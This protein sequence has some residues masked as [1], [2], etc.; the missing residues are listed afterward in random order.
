MFKKLRSLAS[1][2]LV[3][4]L[5]A[6]LLSPII[7]PIAYAQSPHIDIIGLDRYLKAM[8]VNAVNNT[9][10]TDVAFVVRYIGGL[11]GTAQI[12]TGDL[13][14]KVGASGSEIADTTV[15]GCGG[16]AGTLAV[17]SCTTIQTLINRCNAS[18]NWRC[19]PIDSILADSVTGAKLLTLAATT[20]NKPEGLNI[21]WDNTV[22][23]ASTRLL[24]PY[25]APVIPVTGLPYNFRTAAPYLNG[26]GNVN[27]V[28]KP[29]NDLKTF[30]SYFSETTTFGSGTSTIQFLDCDTHFRPTILVAAGSA[31]TCNVVFSVGGGA[32]T[33]QKI[34]T[35]YEFNPFPFTPGNRVLVRLNNSAALTA[36]QL[37]ATAWSS[38][39]R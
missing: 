37:T 30:L 29:F 21:N 38:Q 34:I 9:I 5:S 39:F 16:T 32:T 15:T 2:A 26:V 28:E 33:V 19:V 11:S 27:M 1:T 17:A 4:I 12:A 13:L 10:S 25:T 3:A 22:S 14:L 18:V 23:F 31:E 6:L 35:D 8:P 36:V 24:A 7:E 20:A